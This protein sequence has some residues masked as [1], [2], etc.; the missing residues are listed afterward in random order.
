MFK[1]SASKPIRRPRI[2]FFAAVFLLFLSYILTLISTRKESTQDFWMDHTNEVIHNLDNMVG[3][4]EKSE[5]AFRGYL[6]TNDHEPL[7]KYESGKKMIDSTFSVLQDLTKENV[8][9]QKNLDT[10]QSLIQAKYSWIENYIKNPVSLE[11]VSIENLNGNVEGIANAVAITNTI[12]KMKQEEINLRNS[13]SDKI[14]RYSG[15]IQ[16]LNIISIIIAVLLIIY[17]LLIYNKEKKDKMKAA[18]KA[19]KY[20]QEL[21]ERVNE[22]AKLNTEL[23]ELRRLEKYV[24]TGRIARVMAHEV[25]NP[26]TNINLACEQLRAETETEDSQI[27]FT[28]I[29]RN[30]ERINQLVSDL[31]ATTRAELSFSPAS[32]NEILDDSLYLALDRIQLNQINVEKHFDADIC[33]IPVDA[34][35]LKIAFLNLIV[36]A[37]EAM[38]NN[39]KL[40]ITTKNLP[41]K[42][43][44]KI[45]DNGKGMQK[46]QLDRLFEPYFTTK[47]KGNGL[48]LA[49]CHNIIIGHRGSITAESEVG[50]GTSFT[51]TFPLDNGQEN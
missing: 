34:E 45:S 8:S 18:E 29:K 41:G 25:R 27:F 24:V 2:G 42:C 1:K 12:S 48:G 35:K 6:I 14:S 47:E 15:L 33:S 39:G 7:L 51:I 44:V 28:M 16:V 9:Q 20:K 5:S 40:E 37:I 22:L 23:I 4:L 11:K 49:N 30:S 13:W 31:L 26:L 38:D 50:K 19:E 3:F 17:S 21:Q 43:L 10:L 46:S 36:N 32:I